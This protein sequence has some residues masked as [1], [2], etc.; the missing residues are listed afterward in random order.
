MSVGLLYFELD[1]DTTKFVKQQEALNKQIK[2]VAQNT[3][4][5]LQLGYQNLGVKA[6]AFYQL[7]ANLAIKSY[8][9]ITQ[10]ANTSAAEQVRAQSS[11]VAK[12]NAINQEMTKNPLY[13]QMGIRSMAAINESKAA[14]LRS[15][16][17]LKT[18][19]AGNA[20]EIVRLEKAKNEQLKTLNK[21]MTGEHEMSMASMTR[22]VLRWYAAYYVVSTLVI[23]IKD[24][25]MSGVK[26]I[27][28]MK[29]STIAVA[30]QIT[31]M[32]GTT[33]D[34]VE[35]Y[36]KNIQYAERLIP[37]L[38]RIDAESFANLAQIQ[39]MNTMM[40]L[41]GTIIDVNNSKQIESFTALTNA[42]AMFTQGQD[43][44]KQAS[45][46][47]RALFS[48]QVKEGNTV[49]LMMDQQIRQTGEYKDG[50][51]GLVEEGR[52]HNDTLERMRPYLVGIIT[53]SGDIQNTWQAV[54]SSL[55]T[56]WNIIQR[57][58]FAGIYDEMVEAGQSLTRW[59]RE[60]E[61]A[62]GELNDRIS[63]TYRII[64][65]L[66]DLLPSGGMSATVGGIIG[67][68]L[69]G[70]G[71]FTMVAGLILINEQL[72][73]I[74][75]NVGSLFKKA[76]AGGTAMQNIIDVLK[77]DK[78]WNTGKATFKPGQFG[79]TEDV[80]GS[81][82]SS[83]TS[84]HKS[85]LN[86]YVPKIPEGADKEAL[87]AAKKAADE[88]KKILLDIQNKFINDYANAE[89]E[90]AKANDEQVAAF[91]KK[92]QDMAKENA[93]I[94]ADIKAKQIQD[95]ADAEYDVAKANDEQVAAFY[96]SQKDAAEDLVKAQAD[97]A[98]TYQKI[99][100]DSDT[101]STDS[102]EKAMKRIIAREQEK[103]KIIQDLQ[104]KGLISF[105]QAEEA[106]AKIVDNTAKETQKLNS[107][108]FYK[109]NSERQQ[110]A[111]NL[112][113]SFNTM[114]QLYA[115]DSKE[116]QMLSSASKAATIAEMALLVQKNLMIAVGAV[117]NQGTGDPYSAFARIAAMAAVVAGI[118]Q[119]AGIAFGSS[120]GGAS[121][122][123]AAYG[124][125]TTVLGGANNQGSESI[126]KS[127]ELLQDTYDMEDTK[128]S[129]I[130]NEMK[131]LNSNITGIVKTIVLGDIGNFTPG[132]ILSTPVWEERSNAIWGETIT[133]LSNKIN[134]AI[135]NIP[136]IGS[137]LS[138]IGKFL[139]GGS[140]GEQFLTNSGITVS[141]G[142][143]SPYNNVY[144]SGVNSSWGFGG[145]DPYY[146]RT[147]G[148]TNTT[149]TAFF[150]GPNGVSATMSNM[151]AEIATGFGKDG[152]AASKVI[153]DAFLTL[154]DIDLIGLTTSA[155]IEEAINK[156]LSNLE[157]VAARS[158]FGD[159][160]INK[161]I[162]TNEAAAETV[163]RLYV[164]LQS[165][166]VILEKTGSGMTSV[167][168]SVIELSE[169]LISLAGGLDKLT[170]AADVYYDKFFSDA[171]KQADLQKSLTSIME[172]MN[173]IL[174]DTRAGYR[175]MTEEIQ[176]AMLAGQDWAKTAYVTM[177]QA[178]EAAD[179]YYSVL[180]D[181]NDS[182]IDF[183]DNLKSIT[184]T[185]DEWL[186]NL[187]ISSLA[188]VQSEAEWTRQY[189][190]AKAKAS[191]SG[192]SE[193]DVSA[194]LSYA[195]K[196]LEMQQ[197]YGTADS[198]KA[199]YDAVVEDVEGM[200][201][202]KDLA[203]EVANN[204][205]QAIKDA[206]NA[207]RVAAA[208]SLAQAQ[209]IQAQIAADKALS[210]A[211]ANQ[212]LIDANAQAAATAETAAA[213]L[214]KAGPKPGY[215]SGYYQGDSLWV[216]EEPRDGWIADGYGGWSKL[217]G[218]YAEGGDHPGGWR[219]VGERGPELEYTPPSRIFSNKQT[220]SMLANLDASGNGGEVT[221]HSHIYLDG[222]EI[223]TCV[224][225][226][227][228]TNSDLIQ[229][230]RRAV[231]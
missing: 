105:R 188:P 123:S 86:P 98:E 179:Q 167:G 45:Q 133:D 204:Q 190:E 82:V 195:T 121:V 118:L 14:V 181:A 74:N 207:A 104:D 220:R 161:Y 218:Y 39:K 33:G 209:A 210:D 163:F 124:Q 128:L 10:S 219:M 162:K 201:A 132:K 150:Y 34:I 22:S 9:R 211:A 185:I 54:S 159:D 187:A 223:Q 51:K 203:L 213:N 47:I 197:K 96:K 225:K 152:E 73:K 26:A 30:A 227:F 154:G 217:P 174:P 35:N 93:K 142:S 126:T 231:N 155:Q 134:D 230:A 221:I 180:E 85:E 76:G 25:I 83:F 151:F 200:G 72:E 175:Y 206:D 191:L 31:T 12:I 148:D 49:A 111:S 117:V 112:A 55:E 7:Q 205:L 63:E 62:L 212:A 173:L 194:Y 114:A 29:T 144:T 101:F 27:D 116:R 92:Q 77:G 75:M 184:Q 5:A 140:G 106:K 46:E 143:V 178:A 23:A 216:N 156:K 141:G 32:Q 6:D 228:K 57:R 120:G 208:A 44:E 18:A 4:E 131:Q 108:T 64:K 127:W 170:E 50:L 186:N 21:E 146:T 16:D 169:N 69:L 176:K 97:A 78:D 125:N 15:F 149:L 80:N 56:S 110:I 11:M 165:V 66:Y 171:E 147:Q 102:H 160:F 79:I 103:A 202:G 113:S 168:E 19:A 41:Q 1:L 20:A 71:G 136:I 222:K 53:A 199:I 65:S 137:V 38:Q 13:E 164:D 198:Y 196:Y 153:T 172:G 90:A 17:T 115:E 130:Y 166:S 58:M 40:S 119:I 61:T 135:E 129:G 3:N 109:E 100:V 138:S 91:Y 59:L 224:S 48:G 107:E 36:R 94:L 99:M 84:K 70:P 157:D 28:D 192:A 193:Q 189:N 145:S 2:N 214:L 37:V 42:V 139:M 88:L 95:Y 215:A 52:K 81:W 182:M 87:A 226:G 158:I 24:V 183:V 60:N 229:S 8:E 122:P 89:Y 177:L 68:L 43:K 67:R